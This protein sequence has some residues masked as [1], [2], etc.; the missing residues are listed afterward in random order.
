MFLLSLLPTI[1]ILGDEQKCDFAPAEGTDTVRSL[2]T[3][4]INHVPLL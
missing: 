2:C 4:L 3:L 1:Q